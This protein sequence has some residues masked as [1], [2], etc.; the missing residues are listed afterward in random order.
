MRRL[1]RTVAPARPTLLLVLFCLLAGLPAT[2]LLTP[3]QD[4]VAFGQHIEVGARP[5]EPTLHGPARLVQ[6][7]NTA[8]DLYPLSVWGPLRPQLTMGPIQ[9]NAGAAAVFD[10]Q[11]GPA[12]RDAAVAAIADGFATWFGW[13]GAGLVM[14]TLA[15]A[16][17]AVGLRSLLVLRRVA[18]A[19]QAPP[20]DLLRRSVTAMGRT[21]ATALTVSVL[22]WAACGALAWRGTVDGLRDSSSLAQ[23][24]GATHVP[25]APAG[26]AVTG[27]SGAVIGDSRVSRLG[28]PAVPAT[29]ARAGDGPCRRSTDSLA[30]ELS[31]LLPT[32]VLNLA[33]P[34][35]TVTAGLLGPQQV[36]TAS[37]PAQVGVLQQVQGLRFVVVAIGPNDVGWTDFLRYCYGAPSCND[38]L[39]ANEFGYRLAAF[40]RAYGDLLADLA[41]LPGAPQVIVMTSYGAFA[42]DATC[43]NTHV[44]GYPGLDPGKITLLV[45]RNDQL[46]DVLTGGASKYGYAVARPSLALLCDPAGDGLGPD[47]QGMTDPFP[48]HPTGVG[49]LRMASSVARL[50]DLPSVR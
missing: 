40:D 24:V 15:A 27:F 6:V 31:D 41:S 5:P 28:G 11:Q 34:D 29:A 9:R 43:A 12:A 49:S 1:V 14:F 47:L 37:L 39:S 38:Q 22:A 35:A 48:F 21:T 19:G 23:L 10:P 30:A 7:G 8:M 32:R 18:R 17:G 44:P 36:G 50:V 3:G 25:P 13:A 16:A 33:C 2:I 42:P 20:P 26:P 4:V 45:D 46:N